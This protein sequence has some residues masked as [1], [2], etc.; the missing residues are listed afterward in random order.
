M[1]N[2]PVL[3][4]GGGPVGLSMALALARQNVKSIV[5]ER[6]PQ[7]TNHPK[8]R[9]VNVRTMELFRQW[10]NA[11]EL[12]N[13][14]LPKESRRFIWIR[15]LQGEEITR[16]VMEEACLNQL[17][18]THAS[19]VAQDKIEESL[20]NSIS[21]Y[22]NMTEVQFLKEFISF[23]E[24]ESG[25]TARITNKA[26][27]QEEY[28]S[29]QYLIAADGAHSKIRQQLEINLHGPDNLGEFCSVYCEMDLSA[30]TRHRPCYGYF[31]VDPKR[32]TRFLTTVDGKN[33]W[34]VGLRFAENHLK[35]HYSDAYCINE[36]RELLD[37]PILDI[38]IINKS[39]WKSGAQ[40][41]ERYH[42][43][44]VFLVGDSAHRLPPT[45]AFG[46]NTG[47][48]DA[49]NLAWKLAFVILHRASERLLN[50]YYE[51]R[52][53]IAKQNMQWSQ[54]NAKRFT[55]IYYAIYQNDMAKLKDLLKDQQKHLN[56]AGL[57][58]GFIY[59]SDIINNENSQTINISPSEYAPTTIPGGRAPHVELIKDGCLI[60]TLELFEKDFVL[61]VGC[62]GEQW[63]DVV[64]KLIQDKVYSL[65]VYRVASDGDLIDLH[66]CWYG[67]Y[68][69]SSTGAVLVRPDGHV[70]WR[71]PC[72]TNDAKMMLEKCLVNMM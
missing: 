52:A 64:D 43:G 48:Q 25:I 40:I 32:F 23:D 5:I 21:C 24:S 29:A 47:I 20:F 46:M 30:W 66:Q 9:G 13:H 14:E 61:F 8:A 44:R 7:F 17:S 10:G 22:P 60:S 18:P 1:Q 4:V 72:I 2:V 57:D 35:N 34:I 49:H 38:H 16:V 67:N 39:F 27:D 54:D 62:D 50:S 45:G 56:Y 65:K 70:A 41:A 12:L 15:T 55:D 3:I 26:T 59:H 6:E 51:E 28:I 36:I 69:I 37:S 31:F 19:F 33:R 58:L 11:K 68:E 71:A 63:K 53:P 42:K